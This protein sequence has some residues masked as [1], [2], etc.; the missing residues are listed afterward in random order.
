MNGRVRFGVS[1]LAFI[2]VALLVLLGASAEPVANGGFGGTL[3]VGLT[4]SYPDTLDVSTEAAFGSVEVL[5]AIAERLYDFNA[6]GNVYP[7]LASKLPTISP[8]KLTYTI[9]LRKGIE[10]NDDTPFNAHAVVVSLERDLTLPGSARASDLSPIQTVTTA[11][12][13][14]VVIHLKSRFTPLLQNLATVDGTMMSP[15][16]LQKL[17]T[18]FGTDPVGVGPFMYDSQVPGVSVTVIKSPYYYDKYAVH[19]DKIVFQVESSG[20]SG[21]AALQAGDVQML[22][23]VDP[24]LLPALD[25]DSGVHLIKVNSL[26]WNGIQ[27]NVGNK[28]GLG[29]LPYG[30][31]T[32][33]LA[34]SPLLRQAFEEAIDRNALAKVVYDGAMVPDC[35]PISPESTAVYDPTI[36]CT[37]YDP[38]DAKRLVAK[39]GYTNPTVHLLNSGLIGQF[40]Q[41]EEAAVGI[42]VVLDQEDG[43]TALSDELSGHFDAVAATFTGSPALDKNVYE[44]LATSGDRNFGGYSN[45]SLDEILAN[46]RKATSAKALKTLWHAAFHT[47][48]SDR[49]IIFL[50]HRIDYAAVSSDVKGVEFLSDLQPRVSFAQKS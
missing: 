12:P 41:A 37:P 15:T 26:G 21:V 24:S 27:I 29:N 5:R 16:Q 49:P 11:G 20:A 39:A 47:I 4:R 10:F 42:N 2:A 43:T 17:G 33:P 3:V 7:E 19:L 45:P 22:D 18:N 13:Y 30:G 44:Y 28:N 34:S 25:S 31:V 9:P 6:K 32:T 23:N 1:V 48:I 38:Q 36:R 14:T 35:T 50:G 8:D 40:I 46:A